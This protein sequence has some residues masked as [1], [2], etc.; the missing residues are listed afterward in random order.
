MQICIMKKQVSISEPERLLRFM[1]SFHENHSDDFKALALHLIS[2]SDIE[3]VSLQTNVPI[4]TLYDWQS[5]WNK[6]RNAARKR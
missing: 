4:S 1:N 3:S 2:K 6:K 5:D